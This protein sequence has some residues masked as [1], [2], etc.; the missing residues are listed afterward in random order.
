MSKLEQAL[1]LLTGVIVGATDTAIS[2]SLL[3]HRISSDGH[4]LPTGDVIFIAV[5]LLLSVAWIF[6]Y[7]LRAFHVADRWERRY[8]RA[9]YG[10][11]GNEHEQSYSEL[12]LE[13]DRLRRMLKGKAV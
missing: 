11:G 13:N 4:Y 5:M 3:F 7:G 10:N 1:W 9:F 12:F 6:S 8:T 2:I